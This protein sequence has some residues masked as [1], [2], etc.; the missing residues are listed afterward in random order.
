MAR[1][2]TQGYYLFEDGFYAWYH[3]M[4]AQEKKLEIWKHG[5]I[6]QFKPTYY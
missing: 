5:K 1:T 6:I 3:G 4:S 2:H